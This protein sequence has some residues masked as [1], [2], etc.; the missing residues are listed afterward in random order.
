LQ[1]VVLRVVQLLVQLND[2]GLLERQ[3]LQFKVEHV[4]DRTDHVGDFKHADRLVNMG[5][6]HGVGIIDWSMELVFECQVKLPSYQF[7]VLVLMPDVEQHVVTFNQEF[8]HL[9]ALVER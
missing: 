7:A 6:D 8:C 5:V 1:V 3:T 2:L 9:L 4:G